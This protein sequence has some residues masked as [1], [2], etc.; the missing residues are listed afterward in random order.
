MVD[1]AAGQGAARVRGHLEL[2]RERFFE[3]EFEANGQAQV[4]PRPARYGDA[5]DRP[6]QVEAPQ[7]AIFLPGASGTVAVVS[8]TLDMPSG[9]FHGGIIEA[10]FNDGICG[11]QRGATANDPCPELSTPLV[12]SPA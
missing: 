10:D 7:R 1:D 6:D 12:Q 9:F 3:I 4:V 8:S 11:H 5:H 2:V